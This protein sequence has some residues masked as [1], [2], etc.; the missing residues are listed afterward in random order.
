MESM[1]TGKNNFLDS[2]LQGIPKS[3]RERIIKHYI[4]VKLRYKRDE[5]DSSGISCGK[6]CEEMLRFLQNDLTGTHIGFTEEIKNFANELQK[7]EK[8]D[9]TKGNDSLRIIIPRALLFLYTIRNKRNIGH[10]GGDVEANKIDSETIN[11]ISD[12][13]V[14]E[15]IRIYHNKSLEEAQEIVAAI[16]EKNI[17]EVW[18]I[19]GKKRVLMTNLSAKQKVL[20]LLYSTEEHGVLFEDLIDWVEYSNSSDFKSKVL[21]PLHK[22]SLIEFDR[23]L[24]M[25]ILSPK[26]V[27]DVELLLLKGV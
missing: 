15:L 16:A 13:I 14:C 1:N 19:N 26:G 4:N 27:R 7:L 6:F 21:I 8:V 11:R 17:P 9:K 5:Y 25:A 2:F 3:F 20:L 22:E 24:N 23:E 10:S 12:W 18:N